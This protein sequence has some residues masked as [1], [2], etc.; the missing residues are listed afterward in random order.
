MSAA[1]GR[2][3]LLLAVM[4][5]GLAA[6]GGARAEDAVDPVRGAAADPVRDAAAQPVRDASPADAA[7]AEEPGGSAASAADWK[8]RLDLAVGGLV[9][10]GD[11]ARAHAHLEGLAECTSC[12]S[13]LRGTPDAL[14]LECHDRVAERRAARIGVHGGFEGRCAG[15][16]AEHRGVEADLLGL[17]RESFNHEQALFSLGGAHR[18]V[19]C[20]R[21][22]VRPDPQTG[23][24]RFQTLGLAH[25]RCSDC[26]ADPHAE[27][28]AAGRDCGAC[29]GEASWAVATARSGLE[30]AP[31]GFDH[32]R[33]TRFPLEGRHASVPCEGCHTPERSALEAS[34]E[35]V[36][37]RAAPRDCAS[38]HEDVHQGALGPDCATCHVSAAWRGPGAVFDHARHTD[39]PLDA[40]H[41]PLAC[42]SC[43]ED[44]RFRARG[45]A[46]E[47]CHTDAAA[48]LA[49][50]FDA[51]SGPPDPHHGPV[52]CRGCHPE[53]STGTRLLDY[54]R[55]CVGCHVPAYGQLLLTRKRILDELVVRAEAA[56]RRAELAE[57]RG[58]AGAA[59][60][61]A[62]AADRIARL[63]ASGVHNAELAERL[64][65][66]ELSR[67]DADPPSGSR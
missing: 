57:R 18:E 48:L 17:D 13:G 20:E 7:A 49:G 30:P 46:C 51:A 6:A 23:R 24:E 41:A 15:C 36:P 65:R 2:R 45:R 50:H 19:D 3:S 53:A 21:C 42:G 14:C 10:P 62:R 4:L 67:L 37:G 55:G 1:S 63:A 26:H 60:A 40:L 43:H 66:E 32:D 61:R 22:H 9:S 25:A 39:F 64:L 44:A 52:P 54:E 28:F 11:L 58:D 34:G 12:H 56:L 31:S 16:H 47:D 59:P 35:L 29:H 33:D 5:A 38:C 8:R 27:G